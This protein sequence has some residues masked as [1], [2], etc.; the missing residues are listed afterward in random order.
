MKEHTSKGF[1]IIILIYT[2]NAVLSGLFHLVSPQTELAM[3]QAIER[4]LGGAMLAFAF[5]AG[6][7]YI[8]RIWNRIKIA[9]LMQIAWMILYSITLA[10]GVLKGELLSDAWPSSFIG[11]ALAILLTFFYIREERFNRQNN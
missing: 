3:D 10:W 4:V 5:G 11:A 8:E 6:L 7:A 2:V 1:R 9:V